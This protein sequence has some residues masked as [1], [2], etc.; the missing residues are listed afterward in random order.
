MTSDRCVQCGHDKMQHIYG[1]GACRPGYVCEHHCSSF[2]A[3]RVLTDED[4]LSGLWW[5]DSEYPPAAE[6]AWKSYV[7][8]M[9][10]WERRKS[11][12]A[13]ALR[14]FLEQAERSPYAQSFEEKWEKQQ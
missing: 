6:E 12:Y 2:L 1:S 5:G 8:E 10:E 7:D 4:L 13:S 3:E 11:M 9:H 14:V